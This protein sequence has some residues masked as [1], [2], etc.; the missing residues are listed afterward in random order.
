MIAANIGAL[1][2][3][4]TITGTYFF[5]VIRNADLAIREAE[6]EDLL[7]TIEASLERRFFGYIVRLEVSAA[8][9]PELRAW[10][11]DQLVDRGEGTRDPR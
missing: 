10:L 1:F 11:A 6:S 3:G 7:E 9:P 2:P 8:M 4:K 5:R